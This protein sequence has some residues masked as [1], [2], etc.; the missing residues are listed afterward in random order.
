ML[1]EYAKHALFHRGAVHLRGSVREG[2]LG[3]RE[4]V[5][6]R[7]GR[8]EGGKYSNSETGNANRR[9]LN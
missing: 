4:G 8:K 9:D 1:H 6:A 7:D 3:V 2:G 5:K